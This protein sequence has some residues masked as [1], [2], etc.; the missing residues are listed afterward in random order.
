[1]E[2]LQNRGY[3]VT[4]LQWVRIPVERLVTNA[5]LLLAIL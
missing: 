2:L 5:S 3:T 1:V 4:P